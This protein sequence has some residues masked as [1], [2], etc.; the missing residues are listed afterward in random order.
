MV[1]TVVAPVW[2]RIY[3]RISMAV[4]YRRISIAPIDANAAVAVVAV[5]ATVMVVNRPAYM[6][7]NSAAMVKMASI[8]VTVPGH[9]RACADCQDC[10]NCQGDC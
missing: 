1:A 4:I 7:R 2:H 3:M 5:V 6:H 10:H 9:C 8:V